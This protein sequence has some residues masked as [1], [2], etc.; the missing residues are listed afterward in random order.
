MAQVEMQVG[1][2]RV[3]SLMSREA[4]D[5]LGL[6][7][8]VAAVASVKATNVTVERP[9]WAVKR[10]GLLKRASA[11]DARLRSELPH[12]AVQGAADQDVEVLGR[13]QASL[14]RPKS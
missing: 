6:A 10:S 9:G 11:E 13:G 3:V 7:P 8:G 1:P 12:V 5:E 2:F 4:A 14:G